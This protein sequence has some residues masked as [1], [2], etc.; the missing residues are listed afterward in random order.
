MSEGQTRG[1]LALGFLVNPMFKTME[2]WNAGVVSQVARDED[3]TPIS[4]VIHLRGEGIEEMLEA[5]DAVQQQWDEER[6]AS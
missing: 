2:E 4:A 5:I 1:D 6:E 3:D